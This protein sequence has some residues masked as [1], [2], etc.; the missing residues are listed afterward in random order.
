MDMGRQRTSSK[1]AH[2]YLDNRVCLCGVTGKRASPPLPLRRHIYLLNPQVRHLSNISASLLN[3]ANSDDFQAS[4][5]IPG[6]IGDVPTLHSL[7]KPQKRALILRDQLRYLEPAHLDTFLSGVT[8]DEPPTYKN[9]NGVV[10]PPLTQVT[11]KKDATSFDLGN[12]Q[13]PEEGRG[14]FRTFLTVED[15][16]FEMRTEDPLPKDDAELG[17]VSIHRFVA[18]NMFPLFEAK[19]KAIHARMEK[20]N[21]A[22]RVAYNMLDHPPAKFEEGEVRSRSYP[23]LLLAEFQDFEDLQQP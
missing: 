22:R 2:L 19:Y 20:I 23:V 4:T 14:T 10:H 3:L 9:I 16:R 13:F 15:G 17:S 7:N 18:Q 8:A 1:L 12:V 5:M 21:E 6:D 11:I